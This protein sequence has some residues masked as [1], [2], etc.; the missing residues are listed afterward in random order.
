MCSKFSQN[1]E[2][3]ISIY[4]DIVTGEFEGIFC[5][6]LNKAEIWFDWSY[7]HCSI[8]YLLET[9]DDAFVNIP[10][11]LLKIEN[12]EFSTAA[13]CTRNCEINDPVVR[14]AKYSKKYIV[15]MEDYN[16]SAYPSYWSGGSYIFS[17]D[18]MRKIVP[19][20]RQHPYKLDDVYIGMLGYSTV[21]NVKHYQGFNLVAENC[22]YGNA[23]IAHYP[24]DGKN[25]IFKLFSSMTLTNNVSYSLFLLHMVSQWEKHWSILCKRNC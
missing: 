23:E 17:Q 18:F 15:S 24:A 20:I 12:R 9:D 2:V 21:V 19:F 14:Y 8:D 22:K 16:G 25:F 6:L 5:N 13:I 3:E 11:I 1:F 7:K 10:L 4:K